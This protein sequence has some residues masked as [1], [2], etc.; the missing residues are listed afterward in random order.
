MT[1]MG[2]L[3]I[4]NKKILAVEGKDEVNFFESFLDYL[5]ISDVQI[6]DVGGKQQL[7]NVLPSLAKLRGFSEVEILA[8]VRDADDNGD[9]AFQSIKNILERKCN[10]NPPRKPKVFKDGD[11]LTPDI[12]IYIMPDGESKSGMLEDLCLK[13]VQDNPKM[14]CVN[15]FTDRMSNAPNPPNN[16]TKTK[17]QAFLASMKDNVKNVGIAAKKNY[18]DFDSDVLNSLKQ[19]VSNLK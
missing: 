3:E 8:I 5:D 4:K 6:I 2:D 17:T 7:H 10:L 1:Y 11:E 19:F 15:C 9:G 12:G 16:L 18:W 14:G 13:T